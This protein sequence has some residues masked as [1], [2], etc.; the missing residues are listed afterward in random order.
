LFSYHFD[1]YNEAHNEWNSSGV[2]K[3]FNPFTMS[4]TNMKLFF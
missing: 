2:Y 1:N 4:Q 3:T